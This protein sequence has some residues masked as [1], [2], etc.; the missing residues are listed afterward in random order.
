MCPPISVPLFVNLFF[1]FSPA[2]F[3][4][5]SMLSAYV[6]TKILR[7]FPFYRIDYLF[8]PSSP[9][10]LFFSFSLGFATSIISKF[11]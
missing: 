11:R 7:D 9:P 2:F 10:P 1:C 6:S 4:S 8:S 5:T 3:F